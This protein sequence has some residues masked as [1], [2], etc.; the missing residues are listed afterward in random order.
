MIRLC[1]NCEREYTTKLDRPAGDNRCIQ[2]IF[3]EASREDREQVIS[4]ICS[5]KCWE[6]YLGIP[7]Q[8]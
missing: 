2:N 6:E 3:P 7:A 8:R 5:N 4:G 1:P